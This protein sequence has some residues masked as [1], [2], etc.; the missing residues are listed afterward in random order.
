MPLLPALAL[1]L[2]E[3]A[4][5]NVLDVF[6]QRSQLDRKAI[7]AT[8]AVTQVLAHALRVAYFGSF[9]GAFETQLPWWVYGGA[10]ALAICGTSLAAL[11]LHRMT[12]TGFRRWSRRIIVAVSLTYAAR[13]AWMLAT[14]STT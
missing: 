7:V 14:G 6:F 1:G 9:A 11:V 5:G 4:A 12:D 10:V 2:Q 3:G 8:K 13:G